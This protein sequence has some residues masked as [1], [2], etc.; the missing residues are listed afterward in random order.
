VSK[1]THGINRPEPWDNIHGV[2]VTVEGE[3]RFMTVHIC[4]ACGAWLPLGPANDTAPEV[5]IEK[6]AA[7]IAQDIERM[8]WTVLRRDS[9]E[10]AGW[11]GDGWSAWEG[12]LLDP[13]YLAG[14]L[15]RLISEHDASEGEGS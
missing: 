7:E 11:N 9:L 15:A 10:F 1:C 3:R 4:W 14:C 12:A 6:R 8:G 5:A 13:K 2:L